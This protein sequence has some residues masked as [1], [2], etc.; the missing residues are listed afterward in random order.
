MKRLQK[1]AGFT[2]IELVVVIV[3]LGILAVTAAPKF[4]DLTGDA[5]G[6]TLQ[7][8]KA[9]VETATTG[10]HAKSL[11]AGNHTAL[12]ATN[13][14]VTVAGATIEIGSGWHNA[15]VDNFNDLLDIEFGANEQFNSAV[16][17]D[18][19]FIY[20]SGDTVPTEAAPGNCRVQYTESTNPNVKPVIDIDV[21]G[22]S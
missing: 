20:I 9:A 11:I 14:T 16:D 12:K 6:A 13:P 18:S 2:L 17:D 5:N 4:V 15:T 7:G 8:V 3:I 22:C 1:Q 21:T 10:V 19:F